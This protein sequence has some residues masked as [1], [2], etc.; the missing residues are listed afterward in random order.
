MSKLPYRE[1]D[2]FAVSLRGGGFALGVVARAPKQGKIL[3]GYFFRHRFATVPTANEVPKLRP[4]DAIKVV[5]FGDLFLMGG[6]WPIISHLADWKSEEWPVPK[7]VRHDPLS[8]KAWL[9]SYADADPSIEIGEERC[10]FEIMNYERA[11]LLGAG[12]VEL[13]LTKLLSPTQ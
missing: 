10:E 1:G 4:E 6:D 12:A 7:F 3:L 5:R 11:S 13:A 8:K 2:V 9:I